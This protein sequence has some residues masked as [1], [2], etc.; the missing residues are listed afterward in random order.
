MTVSLQNCWNLFE[1]QEIYTIMFDSTNLCSTF[2]T[3][4]FSPSFIFFL[5]LPSLSLSLF[6]QIFPSGSV[7]I[8]EIRLFCISAC[9]IFY[10]QRSCK[11]RE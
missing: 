2:H 10:L 1:P 4:S 6:H 9:P 7:F 11:T 3:F 8:R 5:S